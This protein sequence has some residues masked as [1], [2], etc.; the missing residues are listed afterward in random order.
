M[1]SK[2]PLPTFLV[3]RV[4]LAEICKSSLF[5]RIVYRELYVTVQRKVQRDM[6]L[7]MEYQVV[8]FSAF[9][10]ESGLIHHNGDT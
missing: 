6:K 8:D 5:D 9:D 1:L 3:N 4:H 7:S 10:T 2:P